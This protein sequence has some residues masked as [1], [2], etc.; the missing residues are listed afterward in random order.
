MLKDFTKEL[1]FE[2][3]TTGNLTTAKALDGQVEFLLMENPEQKIYH[4]V[5]VERNGF[6]QSL[7]SGTK[8]EGIGYTYFG[9]RAYVQFIS[10]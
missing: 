8:F 10:E 5:Q 3:K 6:I 9:E 1:K 4:T 2:T 7:L